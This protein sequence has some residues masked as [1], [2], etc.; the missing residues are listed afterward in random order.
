MVEFDCL[1]GKFSD[2]AIIGEC[3]VLPW[4]RSMAYIYY[5]CVLMQNFMMIYDVIPSHAFL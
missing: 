4:T 2:K 5:I 1:I 3:P